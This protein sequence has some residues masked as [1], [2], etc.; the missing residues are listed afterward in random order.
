M[1]VYIYIYIYIYASVALDARISEV[2]PVFR[3]A[4]RSPADRMLKF[5]T[6]RFPANSSASFSGQIVAFW[7]QPPP[8][9][10][11]SRRPLHCSVSLLSNPSPFDRFQ[12]VS[13]FPVKFSGESTMA[14]PVLRVLWPSTT[15]A[16]AERP[17]PH[18]SRAATHR[19]RVLLL[20]VEQGHR[21]P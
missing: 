16:R 11:R 21:R 17:M 7:R 18:D 6:A 9:Q 14:G 10:G 19:A 1:C 20:T 13:L 15:V 2:Q 8:P 4:T 3:A 5:S 12:F